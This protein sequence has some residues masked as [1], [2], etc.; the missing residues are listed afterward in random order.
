M[1]FLKYSQNY[2]TM[3]IMYFCLK[4]LVQNR[5]FVIKHHTRNTDIIIF[6]QGQWDPFKPQSAKH[7]DVDIDIF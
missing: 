3:W 4:Y 2:V 6:S 7:P 5:L 1:E